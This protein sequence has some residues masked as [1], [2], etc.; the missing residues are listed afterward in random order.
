MKMNRKNLTV[1]M[2]NDGSVAVDRLVGIFEALTKD[3]TDIRIFDAKT[4]KKIYI[5]V[6][7]S[8]FEY[9]KIRKALKKRY[10]DVCKCYY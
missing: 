3:K 6:A 2:T 8:K 9:W 4:L 5:T 10:S 1:E 7:A